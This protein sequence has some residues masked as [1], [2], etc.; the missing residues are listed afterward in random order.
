MT[1]RRYGFD[2]GAMTCMLEFDESNIH[3][4]FVAWVVLMKAIFSCLN[5]KVDD[6]F[7]SYR[8]P[9]VFSKAGHG[10]ASI[11]LARDEFRPVLHPELFWA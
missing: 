10:L 3:R 6:E 4:I 9:E 11:I 8:M 2:N 5:L 7:L 1:V